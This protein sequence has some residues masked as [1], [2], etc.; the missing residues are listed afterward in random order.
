[1]FSGSQK[2]RQPL[3]DKEEIMEQDFDVSEFKLKSL[4][5]Y[6]QT[7][8]TYRCEFHGQTIAL[9]ALDLYK[10]SQFFYKMQKEIE[11]CSS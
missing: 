7:G 4:L 3:Q 11:I 5:E 2:T 10:N 8:G 9:K 6:G 1:M